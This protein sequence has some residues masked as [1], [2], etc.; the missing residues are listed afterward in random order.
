M[1]AW[2]S[3]LLLVKQHCRRAPATQLATKQRASSAPYPQSKFSM[4]P[5]RG[6]WRKQNS[7]TVNP[8]F[9]GMMGRCVCAEFSF[10]LKKK[11][12]FL[13]FPFA[14]TFTAHAS[15]FSLFYTK[16]SQKMNKYFEIKLY[17]LSHSAPSDTG[18][19]QVTASLICKFR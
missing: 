18:R 10:N 16:S 4:T 5:A 19:P 7:K 1:A 9:N 13:H 14:T 8:R 17:E 3:F 2:I 12:L 11:S 15:L 6:T